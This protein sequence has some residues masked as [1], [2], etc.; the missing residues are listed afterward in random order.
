MEEIRWGIIGCGDV[1]EMKSGPAFNKVPHSKLIAVMRR[2][3]VKAENYAK[4]HGVPKWY[5]D[6][7]AL[8]NDA[9]VNA[10][11]IATPP[12]QHEEYT[13]MALEAGKPVYVEKPMTL[14]A[15]AAKRMIEVATRTNVKLSIAHYRRAQPVFI[16]VKELLA[17][18]IIG[19]VRFIDM[20]MRQSINPALIAKPEDNWRINPAISGGGLFHDLAPHQ[21]DLMGYFFGAIKK[22]N[23]MATKQQKNTL[24]DDLVV[25]N[26]LFEN[27]IVFNGTWCFS[28]SEKD[29]IDNC[30]IYGSKGN[31]SFPIFGSKIQTTIDGI[32][33]EY[34]FESL[35]HVQQPMIEQVV[36]FFLGH[37]ENPCSGEEALITMELLDRFT[38]K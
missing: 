22:A 17:E 30:T 2:D 27:G 14:D 24:A 11:Y 7:I 29:E 21:L 32:E 25:G 1:T 28:S 12:L 10:I 8:I 6:A 3:G 19:D 5:D 31:I 15:N 36:N 35:K 20:K 33:K 23:G 37:G 18:N 4:R 34:V 16:K 38:G 26:I 9:E 13:K